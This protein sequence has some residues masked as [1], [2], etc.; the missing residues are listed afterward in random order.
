MTNQ[1][2]ST[3]LALCTLVAT[4]CTNNANQRLTIGDD[5]PLASFPPQVVEVQLD[6]AGEP[7]PPAQPADDT[8][9]ALGL[10]RSNF[11]PLMYRVPIDGT[12]HEFHGRDRLALTNE[13]ARQ[14]GEFP[15]AVTALETGSNAST[16]RQTLE[17]LAQPIYAAGGVV[18]SLLVSSSGAMVSPSGLYE[19]APSP[20]DPLRPGL[21]HTPVQRP[22]GDSTSEPAQDAVTGEADTD[23][24][25]NE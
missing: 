6:E 7:L 20:A 17:V 19:R 21:I 4:G 16:R 5:I 11:E 23:A 1:A 8:P 3:T 18:T 2:I 10:D 25:S 15:T 14:R 13:T 22:A 12:R 9:T 24:Q